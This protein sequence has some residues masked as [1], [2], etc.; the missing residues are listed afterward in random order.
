[1][2]IKKDKYPCIF[3]LTEDCPVRSFW[4]L[5][6]ES[7]VRF[8]ELCIIRSAVEAKNYSIVYE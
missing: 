2:S 7:L 1:M 3:R 6:P 4:K 8:C 5:Q